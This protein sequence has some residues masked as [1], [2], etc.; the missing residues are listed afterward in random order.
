MFIIFAKILMNKNNI[1]AN[2][3]F[4]SNNI[5]SNSVRRL[6]VISINS[7]KF[8]KK[9]FNLILDLFLYCKLNYA[10]CYRER[11]D[12]KHYLVQKSLLSM[13]IP[14]RRSKYICFDFLKE[15]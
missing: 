14:K 7:P 13:I 1:A 12:F 8:K 9:C 10:N 15:I 3:V 5:N 6:G 11:I 4:S 2:I